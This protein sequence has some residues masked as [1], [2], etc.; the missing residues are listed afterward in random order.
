MEAIC[1]FVFHQRIDLVEKARLVGGAFAQDEADGALDVV[2]LLDARRFGFG[3]D[4]PGGGGLES[5]RPEDHAEVGP[6]RRVLM[7]EHDH[8]QAIVRHVPGEVLVYLHH[9]AAEVLAIAPHGQFG[10]GVGRPFRECLGDLLVIP[11]EEEIAEFV[12]V[13]RIGIRWVGDPEVTGF[14][15]VAGVTGN[16][17]RACADWR[18]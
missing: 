13:D 3:T 4:G 15:K 18:P 17:Y 8:L 9:R 5:G 14:A 6:D 1:R 12:V 16:D 10:T 11:G 7:G 2:A